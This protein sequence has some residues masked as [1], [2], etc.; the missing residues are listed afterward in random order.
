MGT[1]SFPI[2]YLLFRSLFA[3]RGCGKPLSTVEKFRIETLFSIFNQLTVIG[4]IPQTMVIPDRKLSKLPSIRPVR[5]GF[6]DTVYPGSGAHVIFVLERLCQLSRLSQFC[7][8]KDIIDFN[9]VLSFRRWELAVASVE[10]G[11]TV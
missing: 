9:D 3:I 6:L 10:A 11:A 1:S 2:I 8:L 5:G 4:A 7:Q